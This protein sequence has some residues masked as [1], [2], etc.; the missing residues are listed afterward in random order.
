MT[1]FLSLWLPIVV[2][3]V[4][5][6]VLSMIIH[7]TPWHRRDYLKLPDEDGVMQ[8]LRPFKLP[9]NDYVTPHPGTGDYM[10]SKEYDAKRAGGPVM[11][12]TVV[13][14]GPWNAG[15]MI[16]LWFLFAVVVSASIACVVGTIVP[17]GGDGHAV[18]HYVAIITFLTYAMGVVP[19]SIW[20]E[21]K[22]ST[23]FKYAVDALLYAL[24]SGWIFSMMWPNL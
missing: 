22:W 12:V 19:M 10:K 2:A 18:F 23:T 3:A 6:F 16:G 9:P 8:A 4:A 5:V 17:P 15:K 20:Y 11:W 7:M 21:R 14:S 1:P 24:A 13:P